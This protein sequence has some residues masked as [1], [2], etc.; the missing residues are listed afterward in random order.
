MNKTNIEK[1]YESREVCRQEVT[2]DCEDE[3]FETMSNAPFK[4]NDN[5]KNCIENGRDFELN[6]LPTHNNSRTDL[7]SPDDICRSNL[8]SSAANIIHRPYVH[9]KGRAPQ[10][11]AEQNFVHSKIEVPNS[12]GQETT[13]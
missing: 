11:P 6:A 2:Q 7:N 5:G 3:F 4:N 1:N 9:S 12:Y 10:P 13:I 8:C